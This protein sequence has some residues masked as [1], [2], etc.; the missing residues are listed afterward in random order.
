MLSLAASALGQ[1][2]QAFF[3]WAADFILSLEWILGQCPRGWLEFQCE[4]H[5]PH[6]SY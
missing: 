3:G 1:S 6:T 5:D 4:G 2:K